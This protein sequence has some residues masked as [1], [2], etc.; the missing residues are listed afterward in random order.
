VRVATYSRKSTTD[1]KNPGKSVADQ[2]REARE[3]AEGRGWTVVAELED[4]GIPASRHSKRVRP[5]FE[6]LVDMIEAGEIGGVVMAEQ[7]R[8]TRRLSVLGTLLEVCADAGVVLVIGSTKVDPSQPEGFLLSG[9]QGVVD[10]SESERIRARIMRGQRGAAL[11]GRPTGH[12]PWGYRR[13]FDPETRKLIRQEPDPEVAPIIGRAVEELLAGRSLRSVAL[14]Y[15]PTGDDKNFKERLLSPAMAG[16]REVRGEIVKRGCWEAII[17][18]E[19]QDAIRALFPGRERIAARRHLLS[20][21]AT[22]SVC[23]KGLRA[24]LR[25]N[26]PRRYY[27]PN[28]GHVTLGA[29]P[30]DEFVTE[31]VL[32]RLTRPESLAAIGS[33][34]V[35]DHAAVRAQI[36]VLRGRLDDLADEVAAGSMTA[37]MA[38]RAEAGVLGQI[39]VLEES[40]RPRPLPPG[41]ADLVRGDAAA[42]WAGLAVEQRILLVRGLVGVVVS[43]VARRGGNRPFDADRVSLEWL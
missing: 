1:R 28:L 39:A 9:I 11:L 32:A 17:T 7:S 8:L 5:N 25:R 43:P 12:T 22:C 24:H 38:G 37:R 15:S 3:E 27:C 20:G 18:D 16:H 10:A 23:G 19:Q 41:L 42:A 21:V 6:R 4:D 29:D 30:L 33:D 2:M 34:P 14:R 35:D 40:I 31:A 36:A 13:V 26:A